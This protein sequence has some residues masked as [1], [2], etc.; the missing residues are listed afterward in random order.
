[1]FQKGHGPLGEGDV[2]VLVTTDGCGPST[3]TPRITWGANGPNTLGVTVKEAP[4]NMPFLDSSWYDA[5]WTWCPTTLHRQSPTTSFG[6]S[7]LRGSRSEST[8]SPLYYL[9]SFK[10]FLETTIFGNEN[11]NDIIEQPQEDVEEGVDIETSPRVCTVNVEVMINACSH[12]VDVS[13]PAVRVIDSSFPHI[14]EWVEPNKCRGYDAAI[15]FRGKPAMK[16]K[17]SLYVRDLV[18]DHRCQPL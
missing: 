9:S 6:A 8:S 12:G 13:A 11:Y 1:M 14:G 2:Y 4:S 16:G 15:S 18:E 3:Y 10:R 17:G 7:S 5:S